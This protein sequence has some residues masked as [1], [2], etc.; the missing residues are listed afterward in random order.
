MADSALA[1]PGLTET[2]DAPGASPAA[3]V[4][5]ASLDA[6]TRTSSLDALVRTSSLA[7]PRE[8]SAPLGDVAGPLAGDVAA[9]RAVGAASPADRESTRPGA[10]ATPGA[11]ATLAEGWST[12]VAVA[13]TVPGTPEALGESPT[14]LGALVVAPVDSTELSTSLADCRAGSPP[15]SP[16]RSP[17]GPPPGL[18]EASGVVPAS[19]CS[20][21][22]RGESA[23]A[24]TLD[25]D[26]TSSPAP[27]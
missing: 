24:S 2:F 12:S 21:H 25:G 5:P 23:L 18:L 27:S 7:G 11:V 26:P 8:P 22:T 16:P 20:A 10:G 4:E 19:T 17:P 6:L 14:A 15:R 13:P 9:A 3:I 1:T